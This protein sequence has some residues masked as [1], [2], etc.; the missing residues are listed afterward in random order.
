MF[1]RIKR[2][3]CLCH[4][5]LGY[6]ILLAAIY[7]TALGYVYGNAKHERNKH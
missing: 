4:R 3:S 6:S 5:A 2:A 1:K 7:A